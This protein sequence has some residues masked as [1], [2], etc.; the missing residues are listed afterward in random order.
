MDQEHRLEIEEI[1]DS[2]ECPYDFKW[3]KQES[4]NLCKAQDVGLE[5]F[6]ECL[7]EHP[8]ECPFSRDLAGIHY[9]KCPC[10]HR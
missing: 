7:E 5:T 9:C 2:L 1:I 10:L 4:E 8:H 6:V 3:Y